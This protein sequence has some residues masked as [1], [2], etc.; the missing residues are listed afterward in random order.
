[1]PQEHIHVSVAWPY[2]NGDMH[3]GHL[4]GAYLPADI[5][6]RYHRLRGNWVL[7]VSGSDSHGTPITV[8][9]DKR[10]ITP[11]E[12]F[13][14][15][16]ERFLETQQKLG[17][18]YDLFTHTDTE[19]HYRIAQDI[20]LLL[21]EKE[22]LYRKKQEQLYSVAENRFLPDRYVEGTCP[23][24][25]YAEARGDQC[26]NCGNILNAV[27]LIN[28]RSKTDGSTPE[29]RETEHYF[30]DFSVFI[31]QLKDYLSDKGD[32]W[33]EAVY[34]EATSK[35][36]DLRER[37]V[38]RDISWGIPVPLDD[39]DWRDKVIYVWLEAVMGY[40]S[41][42]IEWA[43]NNGTPDAWKDWWYNPNARI[44]NFIGKD[45]IFF[46]TVMWQ[47][48]L[49]SISG[50]YGEPNQPFTLPYDVPANQYLNLEGKQFS[51]SRGWYIS[52]PELLDRYDPDSLRYYLTAV[53]PETRDADWD[54]EGFV[55][56]NNS[57]LLAK[58]GNLANRVLKF[59]IRHFNE[60][61]PTP[62]DLR[63]MDE[64]ILAKIDNGLGRVAELYAAVKLRSA[65]QEAIALATEVNVYLDN[66]PWFGQTIKEDKPAAATT[67][68]TAL[69]CI[70]TLKIAFAPVVPF[71]CERIH[72]YMGY[73]DTLF[74]DLTIET[75][76]E[77]TRDHKALVYHP[78]PLVDRWAPSQLPPGQ[79]LRFPERLIP[80]LPPETVA[81]ERT[82]LQQP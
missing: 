62:G 81:E 16:H 31:P 54:W 27:E 69:R 72:Y 41:A 65:L 80:K 50:L 63:P 45:N 17:I 35:V 30:I 10:G 68:Y 44:Y 46:H 51:K 24:C 7:M 70:D 12:L 48:E 78:L 4:A 59:A 26:D 1:M 75:Y 40:L 56:R 38:T 19:N 42:S 60:Q 49:L 79:T 14:E 55:N 22:L 25:G 73:D 2:A 20:F 9:A 3:A 52:A 5:F 23:I 67:I 28:P 66:A 8:E 57:E 43:H 13:E 29:L 61:V 6:A 11:R 74:G 33:R 58:W 47:A 76:Q 53:A 71:V 18:S 37:A 77:E 32:H 15:Y 36:D 21:L 34:R 64:D 39:P 82:R